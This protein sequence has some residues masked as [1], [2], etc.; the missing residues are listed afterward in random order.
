MKPL[1]IFQFYRTKKSAEANKKTF[2]ATFCHPTGTHI[3]RKL[4]RSNL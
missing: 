2:A 4:T 3:E 1:S